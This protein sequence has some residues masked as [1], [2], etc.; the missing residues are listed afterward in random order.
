MSIGLVIKLFLGVRGTFRVEPIVGHKNLF[1]CPECGYLKVDNQNRPF[2]VRLSCPNTD[3]GLVY[4]V[5]PGR[6]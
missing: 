2:P 6:S 1:Q 3:C 4:I 5:A